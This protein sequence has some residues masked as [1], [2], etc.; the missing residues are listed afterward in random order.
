MKWYYW[1]MIIWGIIILWAI[2]EAKHAPYDPYD[3]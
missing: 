3:N 2:W 1:M